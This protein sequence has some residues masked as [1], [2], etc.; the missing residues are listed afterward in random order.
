VTRLP[1][2][3]RLA[4]WYS[5]VVALTLIGFAF[6]MYLAIQAAIHTAVDNELASRLKGI[7]TFLWR[8]L[9]WQSGKELLQEFQEHSG[10]TPGGDLYAVMD[11]EHR[12]VYRPAPMRTLALVP[13]RPERLS[14]ER[15]ET[16]K[17]NGRLVRVLTANVE[18]ANRQYTVQVAT[19]ITAF[20]QVLERLRWLA[21]LV[22][23]AIILCSG[24]GGYWLSGRAMAPIQEIARTARDISEQS[25]S[26]RL[27]LPIARDELRMLSETLNA[28][29]SRL[30][31]AFKRIVQFT[32][33]ASHELRTPVAII[34]T[35]AELMQEQKRSIAEYEEA[36]AQILSEA[37]RTSN[38][39]EELLT[40]ARA[41]SQAADFSFAE[42]DLSEVTREAIAS[43]A[44][45]AQS[46]D[47]LLRSE[48]PR[49]AIIII[50]DANAI[51]RLILVLLDNAIK[52]S[53]A[54][55]GIL[56]T[57]SIQEESAIIAVEDEGI[58][59]SAQDLPH[60]FE[61]FYRAD[62]ARSREMGGAGLGLSIARLIA[63]AHS[64]RIAV[65]STL[66]E[67]STFRVA[68]PL[69]GKGWEQAP[70]GKRLAS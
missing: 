28:M 33:D 10:L 58:G 22:I 63:E 27:P 49:T 43:A 11:S 19:V 12:W 13:D 67:G 16:V 20:Y 5:A 57:V 44:A 14:R 23:P 7:H 40:L 29:L 30:E 50:G 48:I 2:R 68:F 37:E 21:L 25:L 6:G 64:A 36:N 41:D 31:S 32:S 53:M 38:L 45:L 55:T 46:K 54:G 66:G 35:T 52:Y 26:K 65:E 15:Y 9:P 59:I 51:R 24:F 39:I 18:V 8:H 60:I 42:V 62:K 1:I 47:I 56:T 4:A 70:A 17:R 69:R 3:L 61:R 34:R